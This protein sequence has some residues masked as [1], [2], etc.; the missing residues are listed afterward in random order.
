MSNQAENPRPKRIFISGSNHEVK[1]AE[2]FMHLL[3]SWGYRAYSYQVDQAIGSADRTFR[4]ILE[5]EL[6]AADLVLF[7]VSREV[8]WSSWC[9][10]EAG[11]TLLH[12]KEKLM[13]PIPPVSRLE[14]PEIVKLFVEFNFHDVENGFCADRFGKALNSRLKT[15]QNHTPAERLEKEINTELQLAAKR[16]ELVPEKLLLK[17]WPSID[18]KCEESRKSIVE[19]ICRSVQNPV[20]TVTTL[21]VVGVS[22]KF[23]L[24]LVSEALDEAALRH[25]GS[26]RNDSASKTLKIRLVHM[27]SHS[28]ILQALRDERDVG[29]IK[30]SFEKGWEERLKQWK[31]SANN[32]GITLEEPK[33]FAIDY[34]P[35]QLGILVDGEVLFLGQCAFKQT[36]RGGEYQ[37][38]VGECEY[39]HHTW[40]PN[41]R[42]DRLSPE[43][44]LG[45]E[46][47][48]RFNAAVDAY[49][50]PH[51]NA[52]VLL[53]WDREEWIRHLKP[54]IKNAG[55]SEV[56]IISETHYNFEALVVTALECGCCLHI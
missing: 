36:E 53:A 52:S 28:H 56:T 3:N 2:L 12:D 26:G 46:A 34:I 6:K 40:E 37:L 33:R 17:V 18:P 8:R 23:S 48:E 44:V 27:S 1:L 41:S 20:K 11:A 5:E 54:E 25:A 9:Q 39:F 4:R 21:D 7:L 38:L 47:I 49:S 32:A 13:I 10:A 50:R 19:H 30:E 24:K 22:L 45:R 51:L 42:G 14:A 29:F 43:A 35:P 16:Y 15:G 55:N 31:E